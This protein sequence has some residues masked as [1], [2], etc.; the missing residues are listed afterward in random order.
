[1]AAIFTLR[2]RRPDAPRPYRAWGYPVVP[3]LFVL[4]SLGLVASTFLQRPWESLM[5]LALIAAGLPAYYFWRSRATGRP[6]L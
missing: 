4:A 3:A 5:G 6:E 2:R 1:V